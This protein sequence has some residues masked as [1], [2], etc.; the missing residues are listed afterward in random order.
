M[1][2]QSTT[3]EVLLWTRLRKKQVLGY[4]FLR[5]KPILGYILDF[6]CTDLKL[7]IEIDGSS[8]ELKDFSDQ[9]RQKILENIGVNFLRFSNSEI[10]TNP[11][12]AVAVIKKW[13]E[14]N[15]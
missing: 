1:R 10:L 8:H 11:D 9:E 15:T 12:G 3:A 14:K 5:Q 6:Y 13:I 4:G 7:A 2:S